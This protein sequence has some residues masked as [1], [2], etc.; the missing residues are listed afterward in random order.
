[1]RFVYFLNFEGV[2]IYGPYDETGRVHR[3][4]GG[5]GGNA[6]SRLDTCNGRVRPTDGRYVYHMT[7][8]PPY[9]VGCFRGGRGLGV[10]TGRALQKQCPSSSSSVVDDDITP[11]H[12]ATH[13][14]STNMCGMSKTATS[15]VAA[16]TN[17]DGS[18]DGSSTIGSVR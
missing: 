13:H 18:L 9:T 10:A 14:T 17:I 1:M 4:G 6:T 12:D 5:I 2:P 3:W 7:P 8:S 15:V 11:L 16:A